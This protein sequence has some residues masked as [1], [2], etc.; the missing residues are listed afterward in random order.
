MKMR[1]LGITL[2]T[3]A[4][5]GMML[6]GCGASGS[7]A[8]DEPDTDESSA[9]LDT[10]HAGQNQLTEEELLKKIDDYQESIAAAYSTVGTFTTQDIDGNEVTEDIFAE[11][12]LTL[13]NLMATWCNGC[14]NEMPELEALRAQYEA[15]GVDLGI[16]CVVMDTRDNDGSLNEEVIEDAQVLRQNSKAQFPFIVPDLTEFN[17]RAAQTVGFPETFFVDKEGNIVSRPYLG[18][19]DLEGWTEIVE[20]VRSDLEAQ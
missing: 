10:E 5:T 15:Q 11:H 4:V 17:G 14:V 3:I 6:A 1:H 8:A 9:S 20:D 16:V 13:V 7:K 2:M 19:S 18:P 12:E